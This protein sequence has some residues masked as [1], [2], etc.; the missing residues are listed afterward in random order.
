[1]FNPLSEETAINNNNVLR[2]QNLNNLKIFHDK[3]SLI[4]YQMINIIYIDYLYRNSL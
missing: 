2:S 1:M 4:K 3:F